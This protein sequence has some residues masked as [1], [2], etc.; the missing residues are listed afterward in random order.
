MAAESLRDCLRDNPAQ[1]RLPG[2][3]DSL[4]DALSH[5]D[6]DVLRF[7]VGALGCCRE[8][9]TFEPVLK[10]IG[11]SNSSVR[12][13]AISAIGAIGGRRADP[14][15]LQIMRSQK[16]YAPERGDAAAALGKI[17]DPAMLDVLI[18]VVKDRS[19]PSELRCGAARGLGSA[20][21]KRA[22]PP[23]LA[24]L[25][26]RSE[27]AEIRKS[28]INSFVAIRGRQASDVLTRLATAKDEAWL[29][30]RRASLSLAIITGGAIDDAGIVAI[31]AC[32][33][34]PDS[35]EWEHT[36]EPV[37]REIAQNGLTASVRAAA[38]RAL[39]TNEIIGIDEGMFFLILSIVYFSLA[40]GFWVFR[41]RKSLRRK[42]FTLGSLFLLT[43]L[44]ATGLPLV[45]ATWIAW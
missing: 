23:L 14:T 7:V 27:P 31:I 45:V 28:A 22:T 18:A 21:D 24:V 17:D 3:A 26:D 19:A 41:Y 43:A 8:P 16:A 15:L 12:S 13:E 33:S 5:K 38:R 6:C 29:V 36:H 2:L 34:G 42:Q 25:E 20:A 10:M 44:I 9:R 11:D 37:L 40:L 4:V 30:R 39:G 32:D 35:N 1:R